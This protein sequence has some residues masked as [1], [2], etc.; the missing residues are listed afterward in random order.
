MIKDVCARAAKI[1]EIPADAVKWENGHAVPAGSNAG[2]FDPLSLADIAKTA[3][4]TGGPIAGHAHLNA[5]GAGAELRHAH[6]RRR[7]RPGDR[8]ASA[9]C[10]TR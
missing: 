7:G 1:W 9:C 6:R 8:R 10:A 2:K 3:A 5:Q 4:K